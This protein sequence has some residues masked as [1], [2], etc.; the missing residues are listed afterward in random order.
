MDGL[1][2]HGIVAVNRYMHLDPAEEDGT[3]SVTDALWTLKSGRN[4]VS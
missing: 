4:I 2:I 1:C 3:T